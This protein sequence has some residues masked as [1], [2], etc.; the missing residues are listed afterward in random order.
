VS[1][2]LVIVPPLLKYT[3]GPLLGPAMLAGAGRAAGHAVEVLDL[4]AH[5]L[6][7]R[8]GRSASTTGLVGDHDKPVEVL[9]SVAADFRLE[10]ASAIGATAHTSP[11]VLDPI[12][13]GCFE[14]EE[15]LAGARVL[16]D[17]HR[18]F[19]ARHLASPRAPDVVGVSV[20][21]G[22]QLVWA[23]AVSMLVRETWPHALLIWGGP[24][25]TA[26]Q[27]SLRERSDCTSLCDRYV[28]GYAEGTIVDVLRAVDAGEEL[29]AA[30]NVP[31]SGVVVR[32]RDDSSAPPAFD[33]LE[34]YGAPTVTLPAQASRG[35]A[36]ARCTFCTY[37]A[38]EGTYRLLDAASSDPVVALAARI[39]A[40]VSFKDSLLVPDRLRALADAIR[41]CVPWSACTK[42]HTRLVELAPLLAR[43]GCRTLE[44]GLE[45]LVGETQADI[46][47][48]QSGELFL[49]VLGA[50]SRAGIKLVVNYMTGFP[51]ENQAA[52][53]AAL[54]SVRGICA[55]H[56]ATLEHNEFQLERLAPIARSVRVT[57]TWPL[58]S[59]MDWEP[60]RGQLVVSRRGRMNNA[61][62]SELA[63]LGRSELRGGHS[64]SEGQQRRVGRS[65]CGR[66]S[67]GASSHD[68]GRDQVS[69]RPCSRASGSRGKTSPKPARSSSATR[70]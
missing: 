25:V 8:I 31:G 18:G 1:R 68:T 58:A 66:R 42:L 33:E 55:A 12:L 3:A 46:A 24:H 5:F 14:L 13:D 34:L 69:D 57:R 49:C 62:S 9:R 45:T 54:D 39:D 4:N 20:L 52:A 64:G 65:G 36:Y 59:V 50:T 28:I 32:A 48:R 22:G 41:G 26:I 53:A 60:R 47:K 6:V 2:A 43:S 15:L 37:P 35:C 56:G 23:I 44:V 27:D 29:P 67:H 63:E 70:M 19:I 61:A 30:A 17:R 11:R 7:Q 21:F 38:V 16:R 51:G 40:S 10:L